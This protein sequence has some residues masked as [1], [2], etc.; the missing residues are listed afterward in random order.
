MIDILLSESFLSLLAIN[1]IA[2]I[3]M[4]IVYASGQLNLGQAGFLAIGAYTVAVLDVELGWPLLPLLMAGAAVSAVVAVP[5][6]LGASRLRGIYLIMG[7]LAVGEIVRI[8]IGN[9]DEVGGLQGYFGQAPVS[10]GGIFGSLIAVLA[11]AALLMAS[12]V[13]LQ[14]RAVFDD[15]DAAAAAGVATRRIRVLAVV[16]SAATVGVA[17]GLL[18]KWL[19][20]ISPSDFGILKS[21]E[22]ALYT[23]I[24]GVHSLLGA[25]VGATFTSGVDKVLG[26]VERI[27]Y[28]PTALHFLDD[29]RQV[30]YGSLVIVLIAML[31][32]GLVSRSAALRFQRP[33]RRLRRT[34]ERRR[35][36]A[37]APLT[38][39]PRD[40]GAVRLRLDRVGHRYG[41]VVALDGVTLEVRAGEILALIGANGAGK[42]TLIEVVS[43]RVASQ[44]GAVTLDGERIDRLRPERRT[45]A[46]VARTFQSV[47]TFAHLTVEETLRLGAVA[48]ARASR[49]TVDDV[50]NL[51][52]LGDRLDALPAEL[53]L[54]DQR[55]LEIGRALA[56]DPTLLMLDEPSVGMNDDERE[57]LAGL[58]GELRD[59]GIAVV[60]VDHNLDL[61]L[62]LADR[63]AV[64]DFGTLLT[65]ATPQD[66]V[67]DDRVR[68]AYMGVE[69]LAAGAEAVPE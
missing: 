28:I 20:F 56:G 37:A 63:V 60:L 46:G 12:R 10:T 22:I 36:S 68:A 9:I 61:A 53:T 55:R 35:R 64:L 24:G 39:P 19:T 25:L 69:D 50:A 59:R 3:G 54:A 66:V 49:R 41:G 13:G 14:I 32:E 65:V 16:T 29:W 52:G 4:N 58:I 43:G 23:L 26:S 8:A 7:T 62:G 6:A 34:L 48:S 30:I 2:A 47:R 5:I 31:P 57:E 40:R 42:S 17:G 33:F 18:A 51:I 38:P 27:D 1:A 11:L 15:E 44:Q 21:F 45:R 67:N